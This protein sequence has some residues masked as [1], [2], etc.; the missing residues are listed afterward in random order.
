MSEVGSQSGLYEELH[1]CAELI[2]G[3]LA[4]LKDGLSCE[5]SNDCQELGN[6]LIG[7]NKRNWTQTSSR[8]FAILLGLFKTTDR[9]AWA[10]L[11]TNL[12]ANQ[13]GETTMLRL[14]ELADLLEQEQQSVMAR[15]QGL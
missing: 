11:G 6:L 1:E 8:T 14:E 2:D 4:D 10:L 5:G 9:H 7:L 12:L 15:I 13:M 3:V